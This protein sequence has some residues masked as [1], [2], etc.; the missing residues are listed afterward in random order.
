[1]TWRRGVGVP[2][3]ARSTL[4]YGGSTRLLWPTPAAPLPP[5][6]IRCVFCVFSYV[7]YFGIQTL[8]EARYIPIFNFVFYSSYRFDP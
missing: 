1:M 7:V 8:I 6:F 3:P 5:I 4:T 2:A